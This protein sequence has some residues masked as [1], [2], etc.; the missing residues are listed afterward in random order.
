MIYCPLSTLFCSSVA[1]LHCCF[2]HSVPLQLCCSITVLL[3]YSFVPLLRCSVVLPFRCSVAVVIPCSVALLLCHFAMPFLGWPLHPLFV[4]LSALLLLALLL[5]FPIGILLCCSLY[6]LVCCYVP[7]LLGC[8]VGL[9]S[10]CSFHWSR[11]SK[12]ATTIPLPP[13]TNCIEVCKQVLLFLLLH[14]ALD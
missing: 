5:C 1:L 9:F 3:C 6:P 13:P 14:P 2:F 7:L 10:T 11:W 12:W 4:C 8:S